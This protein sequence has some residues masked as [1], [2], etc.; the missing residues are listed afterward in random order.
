MV[1]AADT[2]IDTKGVWESNDVIVFEYDTEDEQELFAIY[3]YRHRLMEQLAI[4]LRSA[5]TPVS[6]RTLVYTKSD[7][8][9]GVQFELTLGPDSSPAWALKTSFDRLC[10]RLIKAVQAEAALE[11]AKSH[12]RRNSFP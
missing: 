3:E 7:K 2:M 11:E 12:S 9:L 4:S 1:G 5:D 10:E 6:T 8:G